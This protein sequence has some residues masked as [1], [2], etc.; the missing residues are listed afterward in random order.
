MQFGQRTTRTVSVRVAI[1]LEVARRWPRCSEYG[2]RLKTQDHLDT[3]PYKSGTT[4]ADI[5]AE[6]PD[7][8]ADWSNTQCLCLA[9]TPLRK[10]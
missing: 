7:E 10:D 3:S 9:T 4:A 6:M 1:R 8:S 5:S 2:C